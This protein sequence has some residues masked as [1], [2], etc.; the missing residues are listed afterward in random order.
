VRGTGDDRSPCLWEQATCH[1][2]SPYPLPARGEGAITTRVPSSPATFMRQCLIG[3]LLETAMQAK[4]LGRPVN[5]PARLQ[6][7]R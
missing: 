1:H 5:P 3:I 4:K 2:P 6:V 7:D